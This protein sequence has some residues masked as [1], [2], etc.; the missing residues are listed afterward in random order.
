MR[1]KPSSRSLAFTLIELL[2]VIAII[3]ILAALLLPALASARDKGMRT[4]CINNQ[5]QIV[6]ALS[7]YEADFTDYMP[8]CN[9]DGGNQL[10]NHVGPQPGWLYDLIGGVIPDPGPGGTYGNNQITAYKTGVIPDPGPGGTYVNNQITAYK[11]GLLYA[12]MPNPKAFLCPVD[13]KS[14]TYQVPSSQ[15]GRN[16]RLSSYVM[17]GAAADFPG[18][19]MSGAPPGGTY[20]ISKSTAVWSTMCY[21]L[22][23]PD[24]NVLGPGNPGAF[25]Y[26]DAANYPRVSNGEGIGVL[27]S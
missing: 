20:Q 13:I 21:L 15:G 22:W 26:N 24:E 12:Y 23:E 5:K 4:V 10:A 9:W 6:L 14:P 11:T 25:E 1:M 19:G 7:M 8:F 27:H 16:N 17:D 3:A 18:S 2:V